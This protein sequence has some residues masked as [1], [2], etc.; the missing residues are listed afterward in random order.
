MYTVVPCKF[1]T[2]TEMKNGYL[3]ESDTVPMVDL[4]WI[5]RYLHVLAES[6]AQTAYQYAHRIKRFLIYLE[7]KGL[8]YD[9]CT[10]E[11]LSRYLRSLQYDTASAITSIAE[12]NLSPSALAAY[13]YPIRGLFVYLYTCKVP[14]RVDITMVRSKAGKNHFLAGITS[15]VIEK[16]DLIL[17]QSY[18]KGG[19][20]REYIKWYTDEQKEVLLSACRTYRDKAIVSISLDGFRIDEIL[21]SRLCD[22]DGTTQIF[23]PYKSKGKGEGEELRSAPLSNRSAEFLEL[24]LLNERGPIELEKF[25]KGE[26]VPEEI[27]LVLR[28]GK[29][30][31]GPLKYRSF[32]NSL[33]TAGRKAGFD[34]TKIRTH[35]GRSTRANEV[36][37]DWAA[38]PDNWSEEDIRDLF[39]WKS[40]TSAEPYIHQSDPERLTA[41]ARKLRRM[42]EERKKIHDNKV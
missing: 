33:K 2:K 23:T 40:L 16:P 29:N 11:D 35:S 26:I 7:E 17:D 38:H 34:P 18:E 19:K 13:Y 20:R 36:F 41:I 28:H 22:Y 15:P 10:D 8:T 42:D 12:Q 27:F 14:I 6:S 4:L 9:T 1:M 21:S 3:I 30:W 31:G 32:W 24:Y 25:N 39:G 37:R 5:N